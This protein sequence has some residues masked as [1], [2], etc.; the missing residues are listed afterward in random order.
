M[1]QLQSQLR[2]VAIDVLRESHGIAKREARTALDDGT[3]TDS[4][5]AAAFLGGNDAPRPT[6]ATR[7]RDW[8]S[9]NRFERQV[10]ATVDEIAR[11]SDVTPVSDLLAQ[12]LDKIDATSSDRVG[13]NEPADEVS[14]PVPMDPA[15][16]S[17]QNATGSLGSG[18]V[19]A[20]R[21]RETGSG[22]T[23]PTTTT[24]LRTG[25]PPTTG[26]SSTRGQSSDS[27]DHGR[28]ADCAI[29]GDGDA[30]AGGPGTETG[31]DGSSFP[32][33]TGSSYND[34]PVSDD[35]SRRCEPE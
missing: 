32:P 9:G 23:S 7:I 13:R 14:T 5:R 17:N 26:D 31:L 12:P 18:S 35:G 1:H 24:T 21:D 16:A 2:R 28:C 11:L 29:V 6:V 10:R 27:G 33:G 8:A 30:T 15:P 34:G 25:S 4:R 19:S 3:W 20:G 22:T